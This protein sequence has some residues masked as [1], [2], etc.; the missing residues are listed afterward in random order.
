MKKG[1]K[2]FRNK[3]FIKDLE[4]ITGIKA[5]TIRI[6]EQRYKIFEPHRTDT[7]IRYYDEQQLRLILNIS[8]LN[9]N[10]FKISKIAEMSLEEIHIKCQE[11]SENK[12]QYNGQIQ[13]LIGIMMLF[14][15]KEF[16]KILSINILK[17]G[18]EETMLQLVFPLLEQ[19][20]LLWLSGSIH[21]AHEHFI[22][23]LV[24]QRLF[25]AID[26]L[27]VSPTSE[28]KKFLVFVPTGES[29]DLSILFA[30][31]ILRS[32]GHQVIYLG[33]QMP[34]EDLFDIFEMHQP[35][36]IFSII[37]SLTSSISVQTFINI[38]AKQWKETEILLSGNQVVNKKDL[39]IP[40]NFTILNNPMM[41][42]SF[43]DDI[44][45]NSKYKY[46]IKNFSQKLNPFLQN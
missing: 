42:L 35:E 10:G 6:W 11:F 45:D 21:P 27:V 31:F 9:N 19:I 2:E 26:G 13:S 33:S 40:S 20:G 3:L 15:E 46:S 1:K 14:D 25:V 22:S 4:N 43:L 44:K 30:N 23:N 34:F 37:T 28:S 24:R 32:R 38:M 18:L 16:N 12:S 29:H 17:I 7:G 39:K 36:F 8:I 41:L 5:H